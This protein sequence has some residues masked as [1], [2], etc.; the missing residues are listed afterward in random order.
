MPPWTVSL[1]LQ[2][3]FKLADRDTFL[4]ADWEY[5][6][7]SP[8]LANV[9]DPKAGAVYFYGYSYTYPSTKYTSLRAGMS[10]GD[11][12]LTAFCENLFDAHPVTNYI[13]GQ[14]DGSFS[15]QQNTYTFRPRTFGLN[16]I[17]HMGAE[18]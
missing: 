12:Q 15:P 14:T 7:R 13:L 8:W 18:H 10:F 3:N 1:G 11:V 2:Y 9:Q 4:R 16:L 5:Q 6:S 17:W